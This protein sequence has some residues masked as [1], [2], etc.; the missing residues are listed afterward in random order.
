MF[1]DFCTLSIVT[2]V[3]VSIEEVSIEKRSL[4]VRCTSTG[5]RVLSMSVTGPG[6]NKTEISDIT[7]AT[8]LLNNGDDSYTGAIIYYY[9]GRMLGIY[10]QSFYC[11]ASN[12]VSSA[13]GC[14][15]LK[16]DYIYFL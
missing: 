8:L 7:A 15:G 5:G 10:R 12:G 16:G 6:L 2:S 13:T 11:T 1:Y 9:T 14:V 4:R 3:S